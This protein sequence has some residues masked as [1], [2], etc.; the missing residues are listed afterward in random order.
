MSTELKNPPGG[1]HT[2]TPSL[3]ILGADKAI[4][5]Y[6]QAFGAQ[7]LYRI[8]GDGGKIMHAEIKIGDSIIMLSDE[9][10]DWGSF[11]P[12]TI[13]GTAS[14]LMIYV[15]DVDSVTDRAVA[16][17]AT[18]L[19]PLSNQF[20]GDRTSTVTDPFGHRWSLA[21]PVEVVSPEEI[22]QRMSQWMSAS[23]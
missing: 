14:T 22:K 13:G 9:F 15:D 16:A 11:S 17:G 3:T 6:I 1:F 21:T 8:A 5:F 10:P 2:V 4:E 23:S 12:Q 7:E 19:H 18:I 20:W